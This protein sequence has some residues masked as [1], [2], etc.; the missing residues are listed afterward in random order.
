MM[1]AIIAVEVSQNKKTGLC[2]ATYAP[3]TTCPRSCPFLGQGCYGMSGNCAFHVNRMLK[4]SKGLNVFELACIEAIKI[5]QL[6]GKLPL[7]LHIVGDCPTDSSARILAEASAAYTA[8]RGQSVWTY[9]HAWRAVKRES[10]GEISV[11]ASCETRRE[12]DDA[13]DRGYAAAIVFT[14]K[15]E[16]QKAKLNWPRPTSSDLMK[17]SCHF[18]RDKLYVQPCLEQRSGIP[19]DECRLCFDDKKMRNLDRVIGFLSHGT[20]AKQVAREI[21][22]KVG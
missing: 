19:C 12:V 8:K 20:G 2:S 1:N 4:S 5:S 18:G 17:P 10:W 14:N 16:L 11:F 15:D 21:A 9:T 22:K 7:R 6:S 3:S 13:R